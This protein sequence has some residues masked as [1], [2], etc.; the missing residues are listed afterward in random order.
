MRRYLPALVTGPCAGAA[1]WAMLRFL[2][3]ASAAAADDPWA[4]HFREQG[5]DA[6]LSWISR[7]GEQ[8]FG[9]IHLR[10]Q[11]R[12]KAIARTPIRSIEVERA[13]VQIV[14]F[15]SSEAAARFSE[16]EGRTK[17]PNPARAELHYHI[18]RTGR[19]L[20]VMRPVQVQTRW[21]TVPDDLAKRV[22][23]AFAAR[24]AGMK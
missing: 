15:P 1:L 19:F 17:V 22:L 2:T 21:R 5:F 24:A 8:N 18:C 16:K 23:K 7:E 3:P 13:D 20:A 10:P 12:D 4:A 6:R 9:M 14:E 11:F